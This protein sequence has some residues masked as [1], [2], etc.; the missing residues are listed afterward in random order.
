MSRQPVTSCFYSFLHLNSGKQLPFNL[1][2]YATAVTPASPDLHSRDFSYHPRPGGCFLKGEI[3]YL[4]FDVDSHSNHDDLYQLLVQLVCCVR[5]LRAS[6][7]KGIVY[8][9]GYFF[10]K[11]WALKRF[12]AYMENG[13]NPVCFMVPALLRITDTYATGFLP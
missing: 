13:N 1:R 7:P 9:I 3:P 4:L 12:V 11:V 10:E 8:L 2:A 5:I 6:E